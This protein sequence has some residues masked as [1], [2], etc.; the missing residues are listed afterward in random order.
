MA[1]KKATKVLSAHLKYLLYRLQLAPMLHRVSFWLARQQQRKQNQLYRLAYPGLV[2]PPDPY[3][4]ETYQL[5]Y[6]K[7]IADGELAAKEI[8]G[9]TKPYLPHTD[10]KILDWGCGVGRIMR[11]LPGIVPTAQLYGAD[12]N[13][14]MVSWNKPHYPQITFTT[15]QSFPPTPY[16]PD[17]FD[18]VYGFSVLT[19]IDAS[20]QQAW[21]EELYRILRPGG[22]LLLTTHGTNYMHQLRLSEKRQLA[23]NGIYTR[24]YPQQGHRMMTS[25]HQPPLFTKI[26]AP[27]FEVREIYEG[28]EHPQ[29]AGGQDLWILQKKAI[30]QA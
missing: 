17:F 2:I 20:A 4:Y 23:A 8:I 7:F 26:L 1:E 19:H 16:A 27:Y 21:I 30:K 29:K 3:I 11:H 22:V 18:L 12:A 5:D 25:W 6:R 14:E 9:W 24:Q 10:L 15:I 28:K 13:E